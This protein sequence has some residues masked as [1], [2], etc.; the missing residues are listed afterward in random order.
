MTV[1]LV[2]MSHQVNVY[3]LQGLQIRRVLRPQEK[4]A[5]WGLAGWQGV[6]G[7]SGLSV[8]FAHRPAWTSHFMLSFITSRQVFECIT[9][10]VATAYTSLVILCIALRA[11]H[12]ERY[13]S[14]YL[15][16]C[17]IL[18]HTSARKLLGSYL[19]DDIS[20]IPGSP[21][22]FQLPRNPKK[23]VSLSKRLYL[24]N[25]CLLASGLLFPLLL[26]LDYTWDNV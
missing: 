12:M 22:W 26:L 23:E 25:K 4:M 19:L 21:L 14:H 18:I 9:Y 6:M 5:G 10:S 13:V 15:S 1:F 11:L 7:V 17:A 16:N 24:V 3:S 20:S 8:R 2:F